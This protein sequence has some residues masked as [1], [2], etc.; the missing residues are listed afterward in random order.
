MIIKIQQGISKR[1]DIQTYT[2]SD[3]VRAKRARGAYSNDL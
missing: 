2:I 3:I 1:K